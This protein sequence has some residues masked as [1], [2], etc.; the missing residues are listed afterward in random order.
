FVR[1]DQTVYLKLNALPG[2]T[3]AG[4][5]A[6]IAELE[7]D[8]DDEANSPKHPREPHTSPGAVNKTLNTKYQASAPLD[9][10]NGILFACAEGTAR[11]HTG[12]LTLA[13]RLA[14]YLSL[15]FR[16]HR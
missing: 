6:Q 8:M 1:P 5:I 13:Q 9:D 16:F 2:Q 4:H 12:H 14:R 3:F 11:I 10:R 15:T 7:R